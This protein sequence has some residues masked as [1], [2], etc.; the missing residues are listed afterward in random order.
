MAAKLDLNVTTRL[1]DLIGTQTSGINTNSTS[2][3][4]IIN[5]D[6]YTASGNGAS[7][8]F[9]TNFDFFVGDGAS[10]TPTTL[11]HDI[12]TDG[13][14][15][16]IA[17]RFFVTGNSSVG[18]NSNV[19]TNSFFEIDLKGCDIAIVNNDTFS[20]QRNVVRGFGTVKLDDVNIAFCAR[21][22]TAGS[23]FGS[24]RVNNNLVVYDWK[25]VTFT[26]PNTR[27]DN[28]ANIQTQG[29]LTT[30]TLNNVAYAGNIAVEFPLGLAQYNTTWGSA[31]VDQE[32]NINSTDLSN[33]MGADIFYSLRM[34]RPQANN[35]SHAANFTRWTV[36]ANNDFSNCVSDVVI[37]DPESVSGMVVR[38]QSGGGDYGQGNYTSILVNGTYPAGGLPLIFVNSSAA[39]NQQDIW[40]GNTVQFT[41]DVADADTDILYTWTTPEDTSVFEWTLSDIRL[42][43]EA[44]TP[45]YPAFTDGGV[46]PS[47]GFFLR[48]NRF[49]MQNADQNRYTS[50]ND[51]ATIDITSYSVFR[52]PYKYL[53]NEGYS[54]TLAL[55]DI[56]NLRLD[57]NGDPEFSNTTSFSTEIDNRLTTTQQDTKPLLTADVTTTS[58]MYATLKVLFQS[59]QTVWP[60]TTN[61]TG[62]TVDLTGFTITADPASDSSISGTDVTLKIP[63]AGLSGTTPDTPGD[64]YVHTTTFIF[65]SISGTP[66]VTT[67]DALI[68]TG[69]TNIVGIPTGVSYAIYD[70]KG[71]TAPSTQFDAGGLAATAPTSTA[72]TINTTYFLVAGGG[73]FQTYGQAII[74]PE[75]GVIAVNLTDVMT[76][77]PNYTADY[78]DGISADTFDHA[79]AN[80][81]GT[82]DSNLIQL[83]TE[84]FGVNT[85]SSSAKYMADEVLS[86]VKYLNFV[87]QNYDAL[88]DDNSDLETRP[89]V[90]NSTGRYRIE[91]I[92]GFAAVVLT[93]L[94]TA[95]SEDYFA[96]NPL[97]QYDET[98][99]NRENI[100]L[101]M[102]V[103]AVLNGT[104]TDFVLGAARIADADIN[105]AILT[106]NAS[107][108]GLIS[109]SETVV[110]DAVAAN[111]TTITDA[112]TATETTVTDAITTS[113][114]DIRGT[115]ASS[116]LTAIQRKVG[117]LYGLV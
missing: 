114:S 66:P 92:G 91:L 59:S 56:A 112:V 97:G 71:D 47:G 21:S 101:D 43:T 10:A 78:Q 40:V 45:V 37:V 95:G 110:T 6:G 108:G 54:V 18:N 55:S 3:L 11:E 32:V 84:G 103:T 117:G 16:N 65:D 38:G 79:I 42:D 82:D 35:N 36:M 58:E 62:V 109:T 5:A 89:I 23:I 94:V 72:L 106:I 61:T 52:G 67:N 4:A 77:D 102:T 26:T 116:D 25:D 85:S 63:L 28:F 12:D 15:G 104:D 105:L 70:A 64:D 33:F 76:A 80:R 75:N 83:S 51:A 41:A 2:Y 49:I 39:E 81:T 30:S 90:F 13:F 98:E 73:E 17:T 19:S 27:A 74:V 8:S 57:D 20:G 48:E 29:I 9:G 93:P 68:A 7:Q 88:D 111:S 22:G 87:A 34:G 14:R 44:N 96:V 113:T 31:S 50:G 107:V 100:L 69:N 46:K 24:N 60:E 99:A 115:N 53:I 1:I 86:D